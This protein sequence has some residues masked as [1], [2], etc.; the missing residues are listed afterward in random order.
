MPDVYRGTELADLSIVDPDHRRPVHWS[1]HS[2]PR[3]RREVRGSYVR[4]RRRG[5][6][7]PFGRFTGLEDNPGTALFTVVARYPLTR[8][9]NAPVTLPLPDS[10]ADRTWTD[11]L[12][13]PSVAPGERSTRRR[14]RRSRRR[15][16]QLTSRRQARSPRGTRTATRKSDSFQ[17]LTTR[18]ACQFYENMPIQL[19]DVVIGAGL[20]YALSTSDYAYDGHMLEPALRHHQA[21]F[22]SLDRDPQEAAREHGLKGIDL[23][24]PCDFHILRSLAK[25]KGCSGPCPRRGG[26]PHPTPEW[27]DVFVDCCVGA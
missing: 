10:L 14:C 7:A 18:K 4:R 1:V 6:M 16:Q 23:Y 22:L 20:D 15:S 13:D 9:P 27:R 12:T 17:N 21:R 8:A 24:H 19:V 2:S 5:P 26:G 11:V 3:R 25:P